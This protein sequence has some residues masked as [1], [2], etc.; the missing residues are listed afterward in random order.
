MTSFIDIRPDKVQGIGIITMA[1]T[2]SDLRSNQLHRRLNNI[3]ALVHWC[4]IRHTMGLDLDSR[5]FTVGDI[6]KCREELDME[7]ISQI[8]TLINNPETF[9][10]IN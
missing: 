6:I 4:S 10:P 5:L 8:E 7:E 3:K 2:T 1:S 9:K